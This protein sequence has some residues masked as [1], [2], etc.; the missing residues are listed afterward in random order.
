[1]LYDWEYLSSNI[2]N[3]IAFSNVFE[4]IDEHT[5]TL[6]V[7]DINGCTDT[8]DVV[9]EVKEVSEIFIP[10]VFTPNG[11]AENETFEIK[12][13]HIYPNNSIVI[14][15]RW[16]DLV[17]KASPYMNDWDGKNAIGGVKPIGEDLVEGTYFFILYPSPSEKGINGTVELIRD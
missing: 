3:N 5:I 13:L 2:S 17:F 6:I 9:I 1:M 16:G 7:T 15:N 4:E 14:F 11:D 8:T 10:N 12:N